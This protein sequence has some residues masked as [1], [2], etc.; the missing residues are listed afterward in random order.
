M[1]LEKRGFY[2]LSA[3]KQA[4]RVTKTRAQAAF[5][6]FFQ[7]SGAKYI[8]VL[9]RS[10]GN[11]PFVN[12]FCTAMR[13]EWILTVISGHTTLETSMKSGCL[14]LVLLVARCGAAAAAD[15][16]TLLRVFLSDGS[17]LV[18]YGEP[19]RVGDR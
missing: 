10:T 9:A 17:G 2:A 4:K 1:L 3:S 14:T 6:G 16:V 8:F 18:R 15:D 5:A 19:A 13:R 7:L 12:S 11:A